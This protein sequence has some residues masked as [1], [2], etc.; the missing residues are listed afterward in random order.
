MRIMMFSKAPL[1]PTLKGNRRRQLTL[2]DQLNAMG[3]EIQF[4]LIPAR[5]MQ[6]FDKKA[7]VNY[8][9]A[10]S[11]HVLK[12]SRLRAISFETRLLRFL[13]RRKIV[14]YL[15]KTTMR[16]SDVD[17]YFDKSVLA[18]A[19]KLISN[20]SP[21]IVIVEYV[22]CSALLDV[23][24]PGTFKIID[25]HDEFSHMF[26]PEAEA[27]GLSRAH[28]I[29]AIQ[30]AEAQLFRV[31]LQKPDSVSVIS[32]ITADPINTDLSRPLGATFIGANFDANNRS[33]EMFITS[34]LPLILSKNSDFKLYVAGTVCDVVPDHPAIVKLGIVSAVADAF[35][36]APILI[37]YIQFGTGIKIK[38]LDSMA[39]GIPTVSTEFGVKGVPRSFLRGVT[40]VSD[41]DPSAF[42]DAVLELLAE[43]ELRER[44]GRRASEDAARWN[45][46]QK[47]TLAALLKEANDVVSQA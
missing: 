32:H 21:Q 24:P 19:K 10:N 22:N 31:L 36:A 29:I 46:E 34:V 28:K 8:F 6:D 2:C 38:L 13:L 12:R 42:A 9:G 18:A 14:G 1:F 37:N 41:N 45:E 15:S 23:A 30:E 3:H 26:T 44:L 47:A 33:I 7:H 43:R 25:T 20:H 16:S 5:Q 27:K 17:L 40:T 4:V 39:L 11:F 35:A